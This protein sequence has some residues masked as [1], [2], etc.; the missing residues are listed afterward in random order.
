LSAQA[1][2]D[3]GKGA[4]GVPGWV[5]EPNNYLIDFPSG[6]QTFRGVPFQVASAKESGHRVCIGVSASPKYAAK[7]QVPVHKPCRTFYLLHAGSGSGATLAKLTIHYEDGSKQ[8]E[9]I[10]RGT[11]VGSFWA[12]E[13]LE[14]NNRY[15]ALAQERMQVAWRGKSGLID[16][17]GVWITSFTPHKSDAV[18]ASLELESMETGSKWFVIGITL[19]NKPPF[20]PPRNDISTGMPNNWGAGCVTAALLEGLAGIEDTG[21][22][23]RSTRISPRWLAAGANEA[24]V[25][26]RYPASRGYVLYHYLH[27]GDAITLDCTSCADKATLR[28]PLPAG[29]R[30]MSLLVNGKV[31]AP[32]RETVEQTEYA[33]VDVEGRGANHCRLELA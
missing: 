30:V 33:V 20:L 25:S 31:V 26:V 7:T 2:C 23:F 19:S 24:Q 18:I 4:D 29:K 10:E 15:G 22:G 3:T 32:R 6:E 11:N 16:N 21:G 17:V 1:N 27:E 13:D 5:D 12:P 9:Y 8:V 14:F 28:V